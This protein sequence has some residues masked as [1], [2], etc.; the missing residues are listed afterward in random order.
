MKPLGL[1]TTYGA[2]VIAMNQKA[3]YQSA[4]VGCGPTGCFLLSLL[5]RS[6]AKALLIAVDDNE[7]SLN[8]AGADRQIHVTPGKEVTYAI[9]AFRVVL[10]VFDPAEGM[11]L[12]YA[13]T[14]SAKASAEGAYVY[15][16]AVTKPGG[17]IIEADLQHQFAGAAIVDAGW[18]MEKRED[19]DEERALHIAFNFAVHLL[20][21]IVN[22]LD[23]GDLDAPIFRDLTGGGVAGFAASHLSDAETVFGL[24]MSRIDKGAVKSGILFLD[25]ATPDVLTRRIFLGV[26]KNLPRE[27]RMN[28][29]R[30]HGLEPFKVMAMLVH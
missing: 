2:I 25:T 7:G 18:V 5:R 26:V 6:Q 4:I 22:A 20:V 28:M 30:V 14:I 15:A 21:F 10:M 8:M 3:S 16:L 1:T 23:S 13:R 24:T 9:G 11:A 17:T 19:K 29:L 12:E 27:A